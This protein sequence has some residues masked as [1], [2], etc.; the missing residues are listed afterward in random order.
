ML[1]CAVMIR[2]DEFLDERS[3][4][5]LRAAVE[6]YINSAEPVAS[7]TIGRNALPMSSATIRS[8]MS[9]LETRGLLFQPHTSA[10]R[11]P[12]SSGYRYYVDELMRPVNLTSAQQGK[13]HISVH[14]TSLRPLMRASADALASAMGLI[15]F[16][17]AVS[18]DGDLHRHLELVRLRESQFLAIH[19]TWSG[20]V[21]HKV[22]RPDRDI[23]QHTLDRAQNYLNAR[24]GGL[25]REATRALVDKERQEGT[26]VPGSLHDRAFQI[27]CLALPEQF[28]QDIDLAVGGKHHL[29]S[30]PEF[31]SGAMAGPV[32][33]ALEPTDTWRTML[34]AFRA[35]YDDP[36]VPSLE[37]TPETAVL[38][39]PEVPI[40]E[41]S[42]CTF[43]AGRISWGEGVDGTVGL[44]GPMR[45][46][47]A[48]AIAVVGFLRNAVRRRTSLPITFAS[49]S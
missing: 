22:V 21:F 32:L 24:F 16:A 42:T 13:A 8:L 2:H 48:T 33:E 23:S 47:Y 41:L 44:I 49:D 46:A 34:K 36:D 28:Q 29:L 11:V 35:N 31:S 17:V 6:A 12:T 30:L 9:R 5:V 4:A 15:G 45:L 38:I 25:T 39:G 18:T 37:N 19:A 20:A 43:V 10:G 14:G 40:P 27:A 7:R 3:Q 26:I 1:A